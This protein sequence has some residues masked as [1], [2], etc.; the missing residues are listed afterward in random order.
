M[1]RIISKNPWRTE[2]NRDLYD[3]MEGKFIVIFGDHRR[4]FKYTGNN[5]AESRANRSKALYL[6][7]DLADSLRYFF[8]NCH[9]KEDLEE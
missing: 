2:D 5:M 8:P 7:R 6:A 9:I 1:E 3:Y 4:E